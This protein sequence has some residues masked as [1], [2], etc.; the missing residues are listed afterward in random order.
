MVNYFYHPKESVFIAGMLH[1]RNYSLLPKEM[2][3]SSQPLDLTIVKRRWKNLE[4]I[5]FQ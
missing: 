5:L 2:K 3:I 4:S 1:N